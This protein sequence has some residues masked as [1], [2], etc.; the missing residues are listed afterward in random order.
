MMTGAA[1]LEWL[2]SLMVKE[3]GGFVD[4]GDEHA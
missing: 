3:G 4:Y 2:Q 1:V